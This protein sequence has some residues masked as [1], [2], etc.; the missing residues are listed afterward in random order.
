MTHVVAD[1]CIRCKYTQLPAAMAH[2][3]ALNQRLSTTWPVI[4]AR[5]SPLPEATRWKNGENKPFDPEQ[6]SGAPL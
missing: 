2:F 1:P 6:S 5:K 4:T 3:L